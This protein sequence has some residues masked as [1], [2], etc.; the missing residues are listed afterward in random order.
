MY[1]Q[2]LR[3]SL[4]RLISRS[5]HKDDQPNGV[6]LLPEQNRLSDRLKSIHLTEEE[7]NSLQ[8]YL[9]TILE[10]RNQDKTSDLA[11]INQSGCIVLEMGE[12][13]FQDFVSHVGGNGLRTFRAIVEGSNSK[14]QSRKLAIMGEHG[15]RLFRVLVRSGNSSLQKN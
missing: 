12:E 11:S 13:E 5:E 4:L 15:V 3:D 1:L 9:T 14:T 8:A 2:H 6:P 10:A 7:V